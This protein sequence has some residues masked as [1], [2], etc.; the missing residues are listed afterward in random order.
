MDSIDRIQEKDVAIHSHK[1]VED[2]SLYWFHKQ[3]E[4]PLQSDFP[5]VQLVTMVRGRDV[6]ILIERKGITHYIVDGVNY[7]SWA[8][9]I[10]REPWQ[11]LLQ[12]PWKGEE[13]GTE[14]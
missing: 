13:N 8:L 5:K 1:Q 11:T 4:V 7:G 10:S 9:G 14:Q 3:V 12:K 2:H 6:D